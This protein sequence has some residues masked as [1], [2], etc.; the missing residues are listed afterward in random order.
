MIGDVKHKKGSKAEAF[1]GKNAKG[2]SFKHIVTPT[3][4]GGGGHKLK[5]SAKAAVKGMRNGVGQRD[6]QN[7]KEQR[8]HKIEAWCQGK[9]DCP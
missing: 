5:H 6:K 3:S 1:K 9:R 7:P 2:Q 8:A 4:E